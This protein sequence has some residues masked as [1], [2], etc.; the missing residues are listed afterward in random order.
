MQKSRD[1]TS[2]PAVNEVTSTTA[3]ENFK[4]TY[5]MQRAKDLAEHAK[6]SLAKDK[7]ITELKRK[8]ASLE[9]QLN[10]TVSSLIL[11]IVWHGLISLRKECLVSYELG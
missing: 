9:E 1:P 8:I 2:K 7:E 10:G 4:K 3:F 11:R 5:T 6:V